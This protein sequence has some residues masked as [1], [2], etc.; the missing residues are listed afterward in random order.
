[1]DVEP[2]AEIIDQMSLKLHQYANNLKRLAKKMRQKKDLEYAQEAMQEIKN[3]FANLR[4]DLL[5]TRPMR[6]YER[7]IRDME[8][9]D[10]ELIEK[11]VVAESA[12]KAMED[13]D[14][15]MNG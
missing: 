7:K 3:C 1:M 8:K 2:T 10:L 5:V 13:R 14:F 12:L 9:R 11:L 6:E 4:T 15:D